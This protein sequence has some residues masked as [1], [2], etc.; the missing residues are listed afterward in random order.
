M[1]PDHAIIQYIQREM[2]ITL[3]KEA[4]TCIIPKQEVGRS[5][6]WILPPSTSETTVHCAV[7][8]A[9]AAAAPYLISYYSQL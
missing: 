2:K 8:Q 3:A 6:S 7:S 5:V 1:D 4:G 9:A